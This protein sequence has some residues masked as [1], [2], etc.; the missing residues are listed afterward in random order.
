MNLFLTFEAKIA[1]KVPGYPQGNP[2]LLILILYFLHDGGM[3]KSFSL[4]EQLPYPLHRPRHAYNSALMRMRLIPPDEADYIDGKLS[5]SMVY[6]C[7]EDLVDL[8]NLAS[9]LGEQGLIA[10]ENGLVQLYGSIYCAKETLQT[11]LLKS[12][13]IGQAES[14]L[15]KR[16]LRISRESAAWVWGYLADSPEN[17]HLD[18]TQ[19]SRINTKASGRDHFILH[20]VHFSS[21]DYLYLGSLKISTP[22]KILLDLLT[23]VI[24]HNEIQLKLMNDLMRA[25]AS[26]GCNHSTLSYILKET[27]YVR[28]REHALE[29]IDSKND[30]LLAEEKTRD[31]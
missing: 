25:G 30:L 18:C 2:A 10:T 4:L 6:R 12:L 11:P 17:L 20:Q 23:G 1:P 13:A 26:N 16:D 22:R 5:D 28:R 3:Q 21:F 31:A 27:K 19:Y 8:S 24:E 9:S 14:V 15:S 29:W 7:L